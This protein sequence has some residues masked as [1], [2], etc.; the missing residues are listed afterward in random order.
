MKTLTKNNLSL[1]LF[2]DEKPLSIQQD[3][4]VVGDPEELIIGDCN[5]N[6][7]TLHG[8]ITAP[9]DWVGGKYFFDGTD[10]ALNPDWV[11]PTQIQSG[12]DV[13]APPPERIAEAYKAMLDVVWVINDAIANPD[14]YTGDETVIQRNVQHLEGMRNADFW[15]DEDM[16][17]ID[18][19]IAAGNAAITE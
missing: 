5:I 4:I 15:T 10:W 8:G 17:P 7:T 11:D 19:A 2:G 18:A 12:L 3:K 14:K 16:T 9:A 13:D 1:Y 6:N